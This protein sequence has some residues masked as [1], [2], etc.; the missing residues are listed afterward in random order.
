MTRR[1]AAVAAAT[2][3]LLLAVW[4]G[5]GT[6]GAAGGASSTSAT[7]AVAAAGQAGQEEIERRLALPPFAYVAESEYDLDDIQSGVIEYQGFAA[8]ID[9]ESD[10]LVAR[11][12]AGSAL[13][14]VAVAP[15]GRR[16]LMTDM[17]EPVLHVFDAESG[18]EV[19]AI[20]LPG[21]E[22]RDPSTWVM[23]A[24]EE[25]GFPYSAMRG[26][27]E[28]VACTPDGSLILV[29]SNA[30]LQ[31]IDA[32]T[33]RVVR[34]IPELLGGQIAVSFDGERAYVACDELDK[35]PPRDLVGWLEVMAKTEDCRLV[36]VDLTTWEV[37]KE[38]PTALVSGIAVK[39]D[40]SEVFFSET[41]KKRV[42]VVDSLTLEDRW[43][44]STGPSFS[45][46]LG[47]VPSGAK[48]YAVCSAD[49]GYMEILGGQT[50]PSIP[51]AED[52]FCAVI[53]TA[54]KEI[55]KRIPLDA[56]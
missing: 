47:F 37:V 50:V 28:G 22:G 34:T 52:F 20:S 55:T 3:C 56:Y 29:T 49:T 32:E 19:L 31:V 13:L 1:V 35:L 45:I 15:D 51:A 42:R 24:L 43:D 41:Y 48:A 2:I 11:P 23:D 8:C 16:F 9:S 36:S 39:P 46:G 5:P 33:D 54:G 44:V 40:D 26:C 30:G 25:G 21:V 38:V 14:S 12:G 27:S 10:A 6:A 7:W 53:D 4:V 17:Y 18:E